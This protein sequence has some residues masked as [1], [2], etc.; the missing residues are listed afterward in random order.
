[1]SVGESSGWMYFVNDEQP[2][3]GASL[4]KVANGDEIRFAYT[5]VAGDLQ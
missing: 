5:V 1:M 4:V 3:Q 2:N